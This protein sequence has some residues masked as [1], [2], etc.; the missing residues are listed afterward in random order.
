M[1]YSYLLLQHIW[2]KDETD[3]DDEDEEDE[4]DE[5]DGITMERSIYP[6][7]NRCYTLSNDIFCMKYCTSSLS[8]KTKRFPR[9]LMSLCLA[10]A[11]K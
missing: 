8:M 6:S 3:E 4:E 2:N 5:D 11:Q 7:T 1:T 10:R 9:D